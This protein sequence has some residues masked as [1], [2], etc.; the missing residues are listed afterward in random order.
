MQREHT[1]CSSVFVSRAMAVS[2]ALKAM[3]TGCPSTPSWLT[4]MRDAG[5]CTLKTGRAPRQR[6]RN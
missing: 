2:A 1:R 6:P 3:S 4:K 5:A